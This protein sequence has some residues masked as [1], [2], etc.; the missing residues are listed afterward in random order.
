MASSDSEPVRPASLDR[1]DIANLAERIGGPVSLPGEAGYMAECA[2][3]NLLTPVRPAVAIGAVD[4]GD[5]Q[6]AVRFAAER[7]LPVAVLATGHQM[8]RS[9]EGAVLINMSRMGAARVDPGRR[10]ARVE[11]GA[12]WRGTLDA[13]GAHG[14]APISGGSSSVGVVGY[15]LGGG[16]GPI[17]GRLHGYAADHV[18]AI[19]VVT[20]DGEARR[21]TASSEPD[22][23]WALLGGTGNFGAVTA[24]EPALFPVRR[25]Y[26]AGL[27]FAGEHMARVLHAWRDWASDLPPEMSSSVAFQRALPAMPDPV[28]GRFVMHLRFT[29]LGPPNEAE[30]AFGPMR[31]LAPALLETAAEAP[32]REAVS[33][34]PDP[35]GPFPWVERSAMLRHFPAAAAEALL[36]VVGPDAQSELSLVEVRRLGAAMEAP[37]ATPNA[38]PGRDA[39]WSVLG[40]GGGDASRSAL[41]QEQLDTL[42]GALAPWTLDERM[43]NLLGAWEGATPQALRAIYGPERYDRLAVIKERYDPRNLFRMNHNIVPA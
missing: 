37:P 7:E 13:A 11:G 35:P 38:V 25:F 3:F 23:F 39:G 43:P 19:E 16:A 12:R 14:L 22:L 21:T 20:A 8:A 2:T 28:R 17:M 33:L 24:L 31:R 32:Y 1:A 5:V 18:R 30:R 27:F 34:F 42:A 10:V 40:I 29:S 15:H 26:G 4:A 6:T 9:A 41:F 36:A